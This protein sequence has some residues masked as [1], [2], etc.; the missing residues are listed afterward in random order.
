MI[1]GI[2]IGLIVGFSLCAF[3]A[4][5]RICRA[6]PIAEDAKTFA[7]IRGGALSKPCEGHVKVEDGWYELERDD[8]GKPRLG[9]KV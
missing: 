7:A 4:A 3:F 6:E 8:S 5:Y 2:A 1:A 9:R